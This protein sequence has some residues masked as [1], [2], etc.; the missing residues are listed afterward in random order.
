[1]SLARKPGPATLADLDALPPTW[2]GE[3]LDGELYAFPRPRFIHTDLEA[4][5]L[6]DLRSPF[7]KGRGGPG[8]WW[9]EIEPGIHL[10]AWWSDFPVE[11]HTDA[12]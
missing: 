2:R 9:I 8:G 4:S 11:P 5:V 10:S 6:D 1:M 3:I 7:Q 12:P